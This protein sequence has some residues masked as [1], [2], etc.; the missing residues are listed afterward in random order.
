MSSMKEC[1]RCRGGMFGNRDVYGE[2]VEC[3]QCGHMINVDRVER[4]LVEA[5]EV[6]K[7]RRTTKR[8]GRQNA[9]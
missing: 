8:R 4:S 7:P 6:K 9:A 1:P 2:Y 5:K 3:I